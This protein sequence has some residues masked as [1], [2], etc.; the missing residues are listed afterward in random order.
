MKRSIEFQSIRCV[1]G[2]FGILLIIHYETVVK[3]SVCVLVV[4]ITPCTKGIICS[5]KSLILY[6][7]IVNPYAVKNCKFFFI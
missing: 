2:S 6:G 3:V 5:D 1:F 4:V 7:L